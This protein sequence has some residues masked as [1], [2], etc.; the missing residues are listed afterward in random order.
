[1]L[2]FCH[3]RLLSIFFLTFLLPVSM[4]LSFASFAILAVM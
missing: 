3:F 2:A 1:M 4:T